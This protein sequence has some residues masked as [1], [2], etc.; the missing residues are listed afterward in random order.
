MKSIFA[1]YS[2]LLPYI[3]ITLVFLA[4]WIYFFNGMLYDDAYIAFRYSSNWAS[5]HG[6]VWNVG[7]NPAEGFSS[8][9]W[10]LIGAAFQLVGILPHIIM[11]W[12]GVAS[13]VLSLLL[14]PKML[15]ALSPAGGLSKTVKLLTFAG[16]ATNSA[17]GFQA[18]HGLETALFALAI[19]LFIYQALVSQTT[20]DY[21]KLAFLSLLIISVRPDGAAVIGPVWLVAFLL[22]PGSRKAVGIGGLAAVGLI[23]AY[24]GI[25]WAY[26]GYPVPNTFYIK[27]A[28]DILAGQNYVIDYLTL[29]APILLFLLYAC[30]RLGL[31][32]TFTDKPLLMLMLPAVLICVAYLGINPILGNVY[33]FLIPTLPLF[34]LAGLRAV[35]LA[36]S[37]P[38]AEPQPRFSLST[39]TL[40]FF[41]IAA[42]LVNILFNVKVYRQYAFLQ[43]Y[44]GAIDKTLVKHGL[45]L[46]AASALS[47]A[48]LLATGDI[49]AIPYFSN[50]PTL[51][52]IGLADETIAH[53]GLTHDY[54]QSRQPDLLILQDLDVTKN[55]LILA[56]GPQGYTNPLL[57]VDSK[58]V[59]LNMVFY[60]KILEAPAMAHNGKGSTYQIV[61]TPSFTADY[62]FILFWNFNQT[63]YYV[64]IRRGYPQFDAL[65]KLIKAENQ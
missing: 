6:P 61:T 37:Q 12:V 21:L 41:T 19:L 60:S 4:L 65:A 46:K 63:R 18:F 24:S 28:A 36:K 56:C 58:Q 39:E 40:I 26:F 9:A 52:I 29:L 35:V 8:F 5:G 50:L 42:M 51:D 25:K 34:V 13:W 1:K 20:Q 15:D 49:G 22:S 47:P 3:L 11:P 44:F 32:R 53:Q 48:P 64:F 17:I 14:L 33:R 16:L 45:G 27:E 59:S 31:V 30:G 23:G 43:G 2:Y 54:I 7:E 57:D 55:S 38:A 10:V 62:E